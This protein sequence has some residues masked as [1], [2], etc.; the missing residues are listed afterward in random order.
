MLL[1]SRG[2]CCHCALPEHQVSE[3]RTVGQ[4]VDCCKTFYGGVKRVPMV[5]FEC[6]RDAFAH[7][8]EVCAAV[9]G[10]QVSTGLALQH[11]ARF[12]HS[13]LRH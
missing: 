5:E 10:C 11:T 1:V 7:P 12:Q 8:S 3:G 4:L 13:E 6:C 9:R 2:G